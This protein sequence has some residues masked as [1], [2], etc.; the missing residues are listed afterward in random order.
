MDRR[1]NKDDQK[2]IDFNKSAKQLL[3]TENFDEKLKVNILRYSI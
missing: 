2:N 3:P 1:R